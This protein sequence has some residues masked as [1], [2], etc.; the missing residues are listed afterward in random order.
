MPH[1]SSNSELTND[2]GQNIPEV[3]PE[4]ALEHALGLATTSDVAPIAKLRST[5]VR[6]ITRRGVMWLGQTCNLRCH[7]CYFIERIKTKSHPEHAFMSL[8]KAKKVCDT[9]VEE[10]DNNAIDIQGGEP[11]IWSGCLD[12]V[13]HCRDI[14][15][16]PTL[17]TN[18]LVLDK[19]ENCEKY[20]EAG[21]RDL[22]VSVHGLGEVHDRVVAQPGAH[23][24][25]MIALKNCQEVG[26]PFRFNC[27][28]SKSVAPQ[29]PAIAKLAVATGARGVNF[30][31]FNPFE[32]QAKGELRSAENVPRYSEVVPHLNEALDILEE[33]GIEANVRYYP[34]CSVDERHRKSMYNFQQLTY[35]HHEWDYASWT[36]TG[37]QPQRMR[38]GDVSPPRALAGTG[39]LHV[40]R[41][42]VNTLM[43]VPV[44][45][46]ALPK[47]H[48]AVM[49][50][51]GGLRDKD[52]LYAENARVRASL[53]C[54]YTYDERCSGCS[55]KEICDGFHGDYSAI[56]GTDEAEPIATDTAIRDPRHYISRQV[57]NV[58]PEDEGWAL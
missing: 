28:L 26:I 33:A 50:K 37:M 48:G 19:R 23:R 47:I 49:G 6:R 57:K 36:W 51:I 30:L 41:K 10:Y 44:L 11:T 43:K 39:A 20:L 58:E 40:L 25:Q 52:S 8:E 1:S 45:K 27:V 13:R 9:L 34:L 21:L 42:P 18:A 32:D 5:K 24:R 31:A 12:L 7:F 56:F 14:G 29:L 22:L 16:I 53:H 15:L 54:S 38:E 46:Q 4:E 2:T 55:V 3:Q 35:D 17:I